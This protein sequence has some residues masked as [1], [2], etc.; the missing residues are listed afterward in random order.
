M[1]FLG[2]CS[3]CG[4]GLLGLEELGW[5][6]GMKPEPEGERD[7]TDSQLRSPWKGS[8]ASRWVVAE[9]PWRTRPLPRP[10][11]GI[12]PTGR[13][14]QPLEMGRAEESMDGS[15]GFINGT[16]DN[17]RKGDE[18]AWVSPGYGTVTRRFADS[19]KGA[20]LSR[21]PPSQTSLPGQR[22]LSLWSG[23]PSSTTPGAPRH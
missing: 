20:G 2:R 19:E 1:N 10:G 13:Q 16:T 12:L 8:R 3:L 15:P 7:Q 5:E 4:A 23:D 11:N 17:S 21:R 18:G 22:L 6:A 9:A 14:G